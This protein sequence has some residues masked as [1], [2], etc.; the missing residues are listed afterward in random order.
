MSSKNACLKYKTLTVEERIAVLDHAKGNPK[1]GCRKL[2]EIFGIGKTQIAAIF[3]EETSIRA[4]YERMGQSGYKRAREG[5]YELI[6]EA[7]Y[8]WYCLA[9]DSM[10]PINGPMLQE[11][12]SA[13]AAR[14]GNYRDFKASS[15]WLECW[16]NRYGIK[17]RA[18]EGESGQVQTEAVESWMERLR[19]LCKGYSPKDIWNEDETGCFFRAL[20]EK[21]LAELGRRCR[22]GKKSK[23]RMTVAFFTNVS[24]DKEEPVVIWRSINPRCFKNLPE[25][26]LRT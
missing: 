7:V 23:L 22:G 26:G 11:E 9:R 15:G 16:K 17:Q 19:E 18:V 3:K 8:K 1:L 10:I 6:N 12:A 2:A 24:G 14:L 25:N 20:T 21:S 5:K 13:I 4:R